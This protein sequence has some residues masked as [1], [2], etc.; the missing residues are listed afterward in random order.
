M[1]QTWNTSIYSMGLNFVTLAKR[2][3]GEIN[4]ESTSIADQRGVCVGLNAPTTT[5]PHPTH[6]HQTNPLPTSAARRVGDLMG[7]GSIQ[8]SWHALLLHHAV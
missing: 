2:G 1:N 7:Y 3:L 5:C 4:K 8:H 6:T